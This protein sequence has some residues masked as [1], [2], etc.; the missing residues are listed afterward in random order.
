MAFCQ[1]KRM[2]LLAVA[3]VTL[4]LGYSSM[5]GAWQCHGTD[6]V[7][8]PRLRAHC[9]KCLVFISPNQAACITIVYAMQDVSRAVK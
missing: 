6:K 9:S 2:W 4:F 3:G 8:C 1:E 5:K 7:G